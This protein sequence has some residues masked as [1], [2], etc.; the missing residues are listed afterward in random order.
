MNQ[1]ALQDSSKEVFGISMEST[2]GMPNFKILSMQ[3]YF[4]TQTTKQK[5]RQIY[6]TVKFAKQNSLSRNLYGRYP[7]TKRVRMSNFKILSLQLYFWTQMTEQ[8]CHY[9]FLLTKLK[10]S[11]LVGICT[12]GISNSKTLSIQFHFWILIT[13]Q[14]C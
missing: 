4:W 10:Y 7:T 6:F 11:I 5:C 12:G 2:L 13:E 14:K 1:N 8:N 9:I 3:F